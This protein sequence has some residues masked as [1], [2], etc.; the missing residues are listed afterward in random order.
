MVK[1]NDS[2]GLNRKG[3]CFLMVKNNF[4]NGYM[5][6]TLLNFYSKD[7]V[8]FTWGYFYI[9]SRKR[10]IM[11]TQN[12]S[13]LSPAFLKSTDQFYHFIFNFWSG[14]LELSSRTL[15]SVF[16]THASNSHRSGVKCSWWG[17]YQ[18]EIIKPFWIELT[19]KGKKK[20]EKW[21]AGTSA[22]SAWKNVVRALS[23]QKERELCLGFLH[24]TLFPSSIAPSLVQN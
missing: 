18:D 4:W 15:F 12:G 10:R 16:S 20:K 6:P 14:S 24:Q 9:K 23:K 7:A 21:R 22:F 19:S 1:Q 13:F 2:W 8:P 11:G 5:Y 17:H 3:N